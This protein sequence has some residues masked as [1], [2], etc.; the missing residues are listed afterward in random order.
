MPIYTF[1]CEHGHAHDALVPRGTAAH[2]CQCGRSA[3]AQPV[4]RTAVA[5]FLRTPVSER[6]VAIKPFEEASAE[7]AYQHERLEEA[8]GERLPPPPLWRMAQVKAR[9]WQAQGITDSLDIPAGR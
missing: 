1:R 6:P 2:G 5:G 9:A 8:R 3:Q 4:Y 7:I